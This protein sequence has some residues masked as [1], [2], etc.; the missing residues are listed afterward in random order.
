MVEQVAFEAGLQMDTHLDTCGVPSAWPSAVPSPLA[1]HWGC[2]FSMDDASLT[3]LGS[4]SLTQRAVLCSAPDV[5]APPP[6]PGF[7][8]S[9]AKPC[10]NLRGGGD[11]GREQGTKWLRVASW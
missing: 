1:S 5:T 11:N 8:Q 3:E 6:S 10:C 7:I 4:C 2:L 9:E